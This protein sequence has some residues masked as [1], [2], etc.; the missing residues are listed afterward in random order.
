[1]QFPNKK[2]DGLHIPNLLSLEDEER[3]KQLISCNMFNSLFISKRIGSES[4][5]GTIWL[6]SI[7]DLSFIIK[8]QSNRNKARSEYEIQNTLS[9]KFPD[10]FLIT[11]GS[12]DC[13]E[14]SLMNNGE[15]YY[16]QRR[17]FYFYGDC[18]RGFSTSNRI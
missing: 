15:N 16:N 10:H 7:E 1:M 2:Y 8:V 14:V 3:L 6:S 13:P 11:Y 18:Y 4:Q 17:K 9:H 5:V 12:I